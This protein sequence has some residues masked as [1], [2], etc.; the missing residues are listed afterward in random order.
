MSNWNLPPGV[1]DADIDRAYGGSSGLRGTYTVVVKRMVE[2]SITLEIEASSEEDARDDA[3]D[4]ASGASGWK[5]MDDYD[6]DI[7]SV[8]GPK[9]VEEDPDDARDARDARIDFEMDRDR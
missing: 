7:E 2:E 4:Q 6:Y 1:T 8:V 5:V 3:L 9:D